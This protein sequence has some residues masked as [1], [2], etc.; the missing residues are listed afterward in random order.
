MGLWQRT[1]HESVHIRDVIWLQILVAEALRITY[2]VL[3]PGYCDYAFS[4]VAYVR[5]SGLRS[6]LQARRK[7]KTRDFRD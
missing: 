5:N 7:H 4:W 1:R 2:V 6:S 3:A